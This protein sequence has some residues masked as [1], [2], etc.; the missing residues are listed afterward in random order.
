LP[1]SNELKEEGIRFAPRVEGSEDEETQA[2]REFPIEENWTV[3]MSMI[4]WCCT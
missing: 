1:D 4:I 3:A 2:E